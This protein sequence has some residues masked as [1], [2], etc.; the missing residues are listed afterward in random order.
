MEFIKKC[1]SKKHSESN[2]ICYCQE[3]DVYMCNKC[4]NFHSELCENH[5]VNN[6]NKEKNEIFTGKCKEKKHKDDLEYFC[7]N[8]NQLCCAAC[9]SKIKGKGNGQHT[10][11]EVCYI[12]DIKK[13]KQNNL[14]DN[15]KYLEDFSN[16]IEQSIKEL[17]K[18]YEEMNEKKEDLKMK[19]SKIFTNIRNNLN[20]RE[21]KI[22]SDIDNQFNNTYF[23]EDL[24]QQCEK[25]PNE[26]NKSLV[27]GK[28][29]NN[30]MNQNSKDL[31]AYIND[32]IFIEN[33]INKIKI[34]EKNINKSNSIK[35]KF[36]FIPE[37]EEINKFLNDI[38]NFGKIINED[39]KDLNSLILII[40]NFK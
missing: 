33:N 23:K 12:E 3:C 20:E 19:V 11:C 35:A 38:K 36:K 4:S 9:I 26:L 15:I 17:K 7:R 30:N 21:D 34:I 37:E 22:L 25:L 16:K 40:K 27:I 1:S 28:N 14:K 32:C 5:H 13:E 6:L 18:I 29:L 10:D 39:I 8:H 2:A 24:V 31:N